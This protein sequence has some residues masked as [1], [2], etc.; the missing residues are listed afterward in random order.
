MPHLLLAVIIST[1]VVRERKEVRKEAWN[2]R[3][4]D[5]K[6]GREGNT[7][8]ADLNSGVQWESIVVCRW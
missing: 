6:E 5:G 8:P 4:E 2:E 7:L 3:K 1:T